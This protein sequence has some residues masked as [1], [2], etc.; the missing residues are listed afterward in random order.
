M[1]VGERG[2]GG[3][4]CIKNEDKCKRARRRRGRGRGRGESTRKD[5]EVDGEQGR[6]VEGAG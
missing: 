2:V 5:E 3:E 6:E 4:I 1:K